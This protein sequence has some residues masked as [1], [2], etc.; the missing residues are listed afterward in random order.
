[1]RITE[2]EL[3][4]KSLE[5]LILLLCQLY[6]KEL[7]SARRVEQKIIEELAAREIVKKDYM[8]RLFNV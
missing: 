3:K 1:M 4:E 5:E 2:K 8:K 7:K 6:T